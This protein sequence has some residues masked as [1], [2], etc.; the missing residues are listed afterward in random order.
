MKNLVKSAEPSELISA[1]MST[2]VV[3]VNPT[4]SADKALQAMVST[5]LEAF[6]LSTKESLSES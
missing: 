1:V 2:K 5:I 3:T 6:S 4:D